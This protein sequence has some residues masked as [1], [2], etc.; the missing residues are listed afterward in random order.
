MLGMSC[1]LNF[2]SSDIRAHRFLK[3]LAHVDC[4]YS[5][6]FARQG[7]SKTSFIWACGLRSV[8]SQILSLDL[9]KELF[10]LELSEMCSDLVV[11]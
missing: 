1:T 5:P 3:I 10:Q 11:K 2:F 9:S 4:D 6:E 8:C 7:F